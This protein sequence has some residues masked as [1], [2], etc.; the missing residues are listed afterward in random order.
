[1]ILDIAGVSLIQSKRLF[2]RILLLLAC[3]FLMSAH[4]EDNYIYL[5]NS[6]SPCGAVSYA[7]NPTLLTSPPFSPAMQPINAAKPYSIVP[8]HWLSPAVTYVTSW[9]MDHGCFGCSA[10]VDLN[11]QL[12]V[13]SLTMHACTVHNR[14]TLPLSTLRGR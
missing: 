12:L 9:P 3:Q 1:M 11:P 6:P 5:V 14:A 10:F 7:I 8:L 4:V 2:L 13:P